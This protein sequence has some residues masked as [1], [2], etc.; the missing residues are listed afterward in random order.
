MKQ[1]A[2]SVNTGI[3]IFLTAAIFLLS[4]PASA[5]EETIA[6][7]FESASEMSAEN[8]IAA[9]LSPAETAEPAT[10]PV[11]SSVAPEPLAAAEEAAPQEMRLDDVMVTATKRE[12][13]SREI[14]VSISAIRGEDL[15]KMG[16]RDIKDFMMQVPGLTMDEDNKGEAGG[17]RLTVRGVGPSGSDGRLSGTDGNQTV[18][19]FIGDIP[20]TDPVGNRMTPDLDPFDLKTVE[21]LKGPQGTTFGA[22]ALN[23]ALRYVPNPAELGL[24]HARGFVDVSR[25]KF[26]SLSKVYGAA[27]NIPLGDTLALRG[28]GVL[29]DAGGLYD[30]IRRDDIDAD[31]RRKLSARG[32]LHWSPTDP[33][34]VDLTYL[35]QRSK[36]DDL[37]TADNAD[38][39]SNSFKPGPS[40]LE[41]EFSLA[42]VDARYDFGDWGSL[43]WQ[44]AQ[45]AKYVEID[46]DASVRAAGQYG[47]ESIR[48]YALSDIDGRTHELRWVSTEGERWSWIVGAFM[49][50]YRLDNRNDTYVGPEEYTQLSALLPI[51]NTPL[52]PR[53]ITPRGIL[54]FGGTIM[55]LM[56]KERSLYG[57]LSLR[58]FDHWE[59]TLGGR[60]YETRIDARLEATG[61]A[62]ATTLV[63][64]GGE[65][66]SQRQQSEKGF[67][68]KVSVAWKPSKSLMVYGLVAKGFQF[69]GVNTPP[70]F[71][72]PN[73]VTGTHPVEYKSSTLWNREIGIR[74]DWFDRTL[75]F[76]ATVY[77]I[78]WSEAQIRQQS[79]NT[80]FT[81]AYIDNI[82]RVRSQGVEGALTWLTPLPGVTLNATGGYNDA[83]TAA[84]TVNNGEA[85][86]AGARLPAAPPVQFSTTLAYSTYFGP[87]VSNA[88]LTYSHWSKTHNNLQK[89]FEIYDF[90][91]YGL[92]LST[93]RPD[94]P[95]APTLSLGL[96]NLTDERGLIGRFGVASQ[97]VVDTSAISN[98]GVGQGWTY[99]RPRTISLRLTAQFD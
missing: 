6:A 48:G 78:D 10:I 97:G 26:A 3:G 61:A 20:M 33:L 80:V 99:I 29:Q 53:N 62:V 23:G 21:V 7:N 76:D 40:N 25:A 59:I 13:S 94:W 58:A 5:A 57:E 22:T 39:F 51:L 14:P 83:R 93:A 30:N 56:A 88:G 34:T 71:N 84:E 24:W 46:A 86:P 15:E 44:S 96:Q 17:R 68:P 32:L 54:L 66:V 43:V 28:V 82:G 38:T 90:S 45:Q 11:T 31:N 98:A 1:D 64:N 89:T 19:Q 75:R 70:L 65:I 63:Q 36:S 12:K 42:S 91:Q 92:N 95:G 72:F 49:Q 50:D 85:T 60:R 9:P 74:T 37:L 81:I 16:A 47:I 77:D 2:R 41:T 73:P 27:A 69:G 67:S 8:E 52:A 4:R 87:W 79:Q 55:P 18:G 35:N